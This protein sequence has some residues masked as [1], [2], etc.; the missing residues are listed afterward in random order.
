MELYTAPKLLGVSL[1]LPLYI[2][3]TFNPASPGL[4]TDTP[5]IRMIT[6]TKV[7]GQ[8]PTLPGTSGSNNSL[9]LKGL[10]KPGPPQKKKTFTSNDINDFSDNKTKLF[11]IH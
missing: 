9:H 2:I 11:L 7:L 6:Q 8:P 4:W 1:L 3:D 10:Q 5:I